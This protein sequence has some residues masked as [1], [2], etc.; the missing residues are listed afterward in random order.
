[1]GE[2]IPITMKKILVIDGNSILNRAFYGLQGNG[3]MLM[4]ADGT[5]TN[6]VYGFL[7]IMLKQFDEVSPDY[8]CVA[9]DLKAPTFRHKRYEG[10]KAQRKG[11]PDELA[12]Q[13]PIIKEILDAMNIKRIEVE[14]YEAD[15]SLGTIARLAEESDVTAFLLTGDRDSFQLISEHVIVRLPVTKGGQTSV[16]LYD[17]A[18]IM[19]KYSV[20]PVQMIDV[21]GLMGDA[22]DNIPGVKGVG[23][24]TALDLI[25]S[26][27]DLEGVY[28]ALG[29][30]EI[31][32]KALKE[33]LTNDKDM[34]FLSRELATICKEVPGLTGLEEYKTEEYD[35]ERLYALFMR[36]GFKSFIDRFNLS[37]SES[38]KEHKNNTLE[39]I[40]DVK[41]LE[42]VCEKAIKAGKLSIYTTYANHCIA[43]IG[44]SIDGE[45]GWKIETA[46]EQAQPSLFDTGLNEERL[47]QEE[48]AKALKGCL[49][50]P[51]VS[52]YGYNMKQFILWCREY[53]ITFHHLH[54]DIALAAYV[55]NPALGSRGMEE[56]CEGYADI[57]AAYIL[58]H[59]GDKACYIERTADAMR[60]KLEEYG[61]LPLYL[62]IEL[63]L[64]EVLASMEYTGFKIDI[65][66]LTKF[67]SALSDSIAETEKI[68]FEMAE[69]VFNINSPK[70]LGVILFEKLK[71]P[72]IKR[73]KTGYS[74]DAE[75][76]EELSS[77]HVIVEK[78]LEYR[79][80][81][82]LK[83]TYAD[84]L[85][86]I[87]NRKTGRLHSNF[88]QT[89]TATGRLSSTEP[90]LQNIPTRH[91]MGR[92]MR[93]IF[94]A[95]DKEHMLVDADYSQIELRVLAHMANDDTMIDAFT[96]D[97]DIH[98]STAA[99]V[100]GIKE[101]DVTKT[102][103][104]QAKAVNFGIVYGIGEFSLAKDLGITRQEAKSYIDNYLDNFSGVRDY[105]NDAKEFAKKN[106]YA[107]TMFNRR[108]YLPELSS[109]N[110]NTRQFGERVAMNAP[111]QGTAAD[112]IKIA[113]IKVY[114]TILDEG[115]KSKLILQVH[116]EL[117]IESP[118]NEVER[119]KVLLKDCME[120]AVLLKAPLVVE[121]KSGYSWYDTK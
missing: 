117:L 102:M 86:S 45:T 88:N 69:E 77:S 121:A 9:F 104:T 33:K 47:S 5:P 18:A 16:D 96:K 44:F 26:Y 63:P 41:E 107:I 53:G 118:I 83:S 82:K 120:H 15:D 52:V 27:N 101:D 93:K 91:E 4:S 109:S 56:I 28:D 54:D 110:Y 35:N 37:Q 80:L 97:A 94:V 66:E 13:L 8:I 40:T 31:T 1:M 116:D 99:Q 38:Q 115:L 112:I 67:Q 87:V 90:N 51:D 75:V 2:R 46:D 113:M 108:R 62:D 48:L 85:L 103:R 42:K 12:V 105:M 11:M 111:I 57:T 36:L 20:A 24:K 81:A 60:K 17:T 78:I 98:A 92:K 22:S 72:V 25:T 61:Q 84:G 100:F 14:G 68:I 10:Y 23:E 50:S 114:K 119:V 95:E 59:P 73:T 3:G 55:L 89:I 43:Q 71:L 32:K 70:Q 34:A 29:R 65:D 49:E 76:L 39:E 30:G 74:T 106:G 7:T 21:K 79:Q 19:D 64:I 6:A 58:D